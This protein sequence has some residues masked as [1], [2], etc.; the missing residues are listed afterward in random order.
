[1]TIDTELYTDPELIGIQPMGGF[2]HWCPICDGGLFYSSKH[3]AFVC[4]V[5]GTIF[6]M[7]DIFLYDQEVIW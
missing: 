7:D 2:Y 4:T 5:C 3:Q 6:P 1:M